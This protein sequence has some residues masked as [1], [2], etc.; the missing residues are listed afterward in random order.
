MALLCCGE[1]KESAVEGTEAN[2]DV[3]CY[4]YDREFINPQQFQRIL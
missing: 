4:V 3:Q 2:G 1:Q